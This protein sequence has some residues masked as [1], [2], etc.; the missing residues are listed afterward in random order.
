MVSSNKDTYT[1]AALTLARDAAG[2]IDT[3][4]LA[5]P[6]WAHIGVRYN[7]LAVVVV[8][9]TEQSSSAS[10]CVKSSHSTRSK[11]LVERSSRA[12]RVLKLN[13]AC[14]VGTG[15]GVTGAAVVGSA[16]VGWAVTGSAVV[17][18]AVTGAAVVG[19]AVTGAAVVG[20]VVGV[21]GR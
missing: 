3:L 4:A 5:G 1:L 19:S 17:G 10:T 11:L 14:R 13:A 9:I 12:P 6:K 15:G 2:S 7:T 16:V 8:V 20:G 18:S 21:G